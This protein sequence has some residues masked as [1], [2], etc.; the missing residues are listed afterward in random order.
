MPTGVY[1]VYV[2]DIPQSTTGSTQFTLGFAS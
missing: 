2:N 1:S